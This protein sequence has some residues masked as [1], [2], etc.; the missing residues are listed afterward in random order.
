MD[1]AEEWRRLREFYAGMNEGELEV[2]ASEAYD[3]TDV[4]KPLLK[5]EIARRGLKIPLRSERPPRGV[6]APRSSYAEVSGTDLTV[7]GTVWSVED[8]RTAK[9]F[10]DTGGVPHAWGPDNLETLDGLRFEDGIDLKVREEDSPRVFA[11]LGRLF[12]PPADRDAKE[13]IVECPQCHSSE[14]VFLDLDGETGKF[15]WSC[16]ACGYGWADDGVA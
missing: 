12:S 7:A 5:D 1:Q 16:E 3:L 15:N 14:I 6:P 10:L 4:A 8:A 2:V 11:A 9:A 13:C